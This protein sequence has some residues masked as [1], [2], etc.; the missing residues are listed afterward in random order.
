MNVVDIHRQGRGTPIVVYCVRVRTLAAALPHDHSRTHFIRVP[1][2][3]HS[4]RYTFTMVDCTNSISFICHLFNVLLVSVALAFMVFSND[5]MKY[6]LSRLFLLSIYF[7]SYSMFF[8][9]F[10]EWYMVN[11]VLLKSSAYNFYSF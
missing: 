4:H 6:C 1:D 7:L 2:P 10:S 5:S 3:R 11:V 9:F 8:E